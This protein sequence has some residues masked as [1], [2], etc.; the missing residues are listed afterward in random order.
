MSISS[1]QT[2]AISSSSPSIIASSSPTYKSSLQQLNSS[3]SYS[4]STSK[5][6]IG[7]PS[8]PLRPITSSSGFIYP[9]IWSFPPFFTLQPNTQTL[10]HQLNLWTN[11]ILNWAKFERVWRVDTE[12]V[13]PG[14]VFSNRSIQRES[15][16]S[17]I[18]Y[19]FHT[20]D[21]RERKGD[22]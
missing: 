22:Y 12:G 20:V 21:H 15:Y 4:D 6:P 8:T 18:Y 3:N 1:P 19:V 16:L 10:A 9:A 11:L 14:E 17:H 7:N 2:T 5:S 13:E